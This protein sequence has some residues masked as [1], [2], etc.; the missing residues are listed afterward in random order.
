[1]AQITI[2]VPNSDALDVLAALERAWSVQAGNRHDNY[3]SFTNNQKAAACI[4]E[5]LRSI[6]K[7]HRHSAEVERRRR[8]EAPIEIAEPDIR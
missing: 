7:A 4:G 1:M 6:T 8:Q 2:T 3:S 5:Y